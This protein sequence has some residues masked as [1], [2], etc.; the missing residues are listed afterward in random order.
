MQQKPPIVKTFYDASGL[1]AHNRWL[2]VVSENVGSNAGLAEFLGVSESTIRRWNN[3]HNESQPSTLL[4]YQ[5]CNEWDISPAWLF[6]GTGPKRLS[7]LA[8][9][10]RRYKTLEILEEV[11]ERLAAIMARLDEAE[12]K[13][14]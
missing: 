10:H 6:W 13:Q 8:Y 14:E 9:M 12:K 2:K 4:L 5:C 11:D 1:A 3:P 7:D